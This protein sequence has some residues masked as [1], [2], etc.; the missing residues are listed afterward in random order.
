MG[1]N[2]S[3]F[4]HDVVF[5]A[6]WNNNEKKSFGC[7]AFHS[8]KSAIN[9]ASKKLELEPTLNIH[10]L[11]IETDDERNKTQDI[12]W[13]YY[14]DDTLRGSRS[15]RASPVPSAVSSVGV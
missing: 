11:R 9:F 14:L 1:N 8:A 15:S 10:V 4:K 7:K 3:V 5:V 12:F 2:T 13:K 6:E